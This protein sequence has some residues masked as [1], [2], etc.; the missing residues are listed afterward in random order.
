MT[1]TPE[2]E[3]KHRKSQ[4]PGHYQ[5]RGGVRIAQHIPLRIR[6]ASAVS[7]RHPVVGQQGAP[8]GRM[9]DPGPCEGQREKK[10]P[11]PGRQPKVGEAVARL[12]R[13]RQQQPAAHCAHHG[14]ATDPQHAPPSPQR[15]RPAQRVQQPI[16]ECGQPRQDRFEES[17][18]CRSDRAKECR[19]GTPLPVTKRLLFEGRSGC[20]REN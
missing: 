5:G 6:Q 20:S 14:N 18:Q 11:L 9:N 12:G 2:N 16:D 17:S 15:A 8:G 1:V 10:R 4:Q 19:H 7:V 3:S 13:G